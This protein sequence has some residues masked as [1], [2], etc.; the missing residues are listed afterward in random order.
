MLLVAALLREATAFYA[1]IRS[2]HI[3]LGRLFGEM[4][5]IDDQ[6]RNCAA[7]RSLG[8]DAIEFRGATELRAELSRRGVLPRP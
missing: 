8:I 4:A 5:L 7:A 6:P 2:G 3:D 1:R